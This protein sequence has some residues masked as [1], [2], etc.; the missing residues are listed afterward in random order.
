MQRLPQITYKAVYLLPILQPIQKQSHSPANSVTFFE[1]LEKTNSIVNNL[2]SQ[3]KSGN[4]E[5]LQYT[6]K[7]EVIQ[8]LNDKIIRNIDILNQN[9][10]LL[11]LRWI[12]FELQ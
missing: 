8:S 12:Q 9:W 7:L 3:I 10:H 2:K 5:L 6:R 1:T 4:K 11:R